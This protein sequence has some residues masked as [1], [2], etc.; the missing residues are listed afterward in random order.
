ML[1]LKPKRVPELRTEEGFQT[2]FQGINEKRMRR[3]LETAYEHLKDR[4][5]EKKVQRRLK[6]LNGHMVK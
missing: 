4:E 6:L 5:R 1:K 3:L 2:F